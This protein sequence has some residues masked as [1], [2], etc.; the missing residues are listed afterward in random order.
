MRGEPKTLYLAAEAKS[1]AEDI[2]IDFAVMERA[3]NLCVVPFA[4]GWSDL[5]NWDAIWRESG[6]D[7]DGM[8]TT[9]DAILVA[10]KSRMQELKEAVARLKARYAVQAEGFAQTTWPETGYQR[11][12]VIA[13][14]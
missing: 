6:S 7:A 10:H 4:A 5:G 8:V 11:Q 13:A 3:A 14:E 12:F 1:S 2:S 9:G